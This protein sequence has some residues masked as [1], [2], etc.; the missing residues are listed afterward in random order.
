[1]TLD[2]IHLALVHPAKLVPRPFLFDRPKGRS[3]L[4]AH[5]R[6]LAVGDELTRRFLALPCRSK[7]FC[8]PIRNAAIED[9]MTV[10]RLDLGMIADTAVILAT[11]PKL[12]V[13]KKG[14]KS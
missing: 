6:K 1:M 3:N 12:K 11:A 2:N 8:K 7:T 9:Y 4:A 10:A 13:A 14:G 5:K